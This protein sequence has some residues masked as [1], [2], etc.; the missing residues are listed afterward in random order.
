M[1]RKSGST[2][3]ILA[4]SNTLRNQLSQGMSAPDILAS[5]KPDEAEFNQQRRPFLMY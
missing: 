5:W 3:D 2:F 1:W 4:G